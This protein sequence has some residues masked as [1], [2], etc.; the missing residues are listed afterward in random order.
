MDAAGGD[1]KR[2]KKEEKEKLQHLPYKKDIGKKLFKSPQCFVL[3]SGQSRWL[4][5][6]QQ[7]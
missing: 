2:A 6:L 4:E 3:L 1:E 7:C 5:E